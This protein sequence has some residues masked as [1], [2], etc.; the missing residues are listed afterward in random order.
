MSA[1]PDS[2]ST[3]HRSARAKTPRRNVPRQP[4]QGAGVEQPDGKLVSADIHPHPQAAEL[5]A[6]EQRIRIAAYLLAEQRGFAPGHEREDWLAAEA[7]I[8]R[9]MAIEIPAGF[10]G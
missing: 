3:K 7:E 5:P 8:D 1:K 9:L 2:I 6:R 10:L 4:K